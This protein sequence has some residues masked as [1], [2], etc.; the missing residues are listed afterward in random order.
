MSLPDL[1][2]YV[3]HRSTPDADFEGTPVPGLRA[4][5][6]RRPDGDRI[7]SV[8]CYS[9]GGREVLRAW[10]FVDEEHCRRH[11]VLDPERGWGPVVEGCPD[12]RFRRHGDAVV[13]LEV[14]TPKG[15]WI[16]VGG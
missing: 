8:G 7:A 15:E 2:E 4:D 6:Y 13:G 3:P 5:F 11:A 14:R 16:T 9:Y 10:G 1:A 12:V